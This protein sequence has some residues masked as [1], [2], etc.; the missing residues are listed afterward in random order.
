MIV[1]GNNEMF[2][3]SAEITHNS[4]GWIL[5]RFRFV[6][7]SRLCGNWQDETDLRACYGWLHDFADKPRRRFEPGLLDLSA[8]AIFERLV[9]PV[10]KDADEARIPE[11]YED[12]F[13]RFHIEHLG[14]SSFDRVIMVLI[15][16]PEKQRCVWK[17]DQDERIY[18]DSFPCGHMQQVAKEFCKL[19]EAEL[20]GLGMMM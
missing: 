8:E 17:D 5:G 20:T 10:L 15:E 2:A 12:T 13:S 19:F 3:I 18:D 9:R 1:A 14:M 6:L 16:G 7:H 4:S 11:F